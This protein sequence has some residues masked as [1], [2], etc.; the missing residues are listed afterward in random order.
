[1]RFLLDTNVL[2]TLED[3]SQAFSGDL[4]DFVRLAQGNGHDLAYHEASHRDFDRD[5]DGVRRKRNL[6]RIRQYECL[7]GFPECPWNGP[8]TSPNDAVDNEILYAISLSAAHYLV[9]EDKAILRAAKRRGLRDSVMAIQEAAQYLRQLHE[10]KAVSLP[11]I[12]DTPL[13]VLTP[14]LSSAFFDSLRGGYEGFDRWFRKKAADGRRA[15]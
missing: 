9:T 12:L 14:G 15:W 2:I 8:D 1:M 5:I 13:Y 3:S 4:A 6:E 7:P 11:N 10:R